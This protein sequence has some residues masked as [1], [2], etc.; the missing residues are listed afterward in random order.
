MTTPKDGTRIYSGVRGEI[1]VSFL[2]GYLRF[3]NEKGEQ[4]GMKHCAHYFDEM[5][6]ENGQEPGMRGEKV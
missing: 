3:Y 5:V 2:D 4:I 1:W 6:N